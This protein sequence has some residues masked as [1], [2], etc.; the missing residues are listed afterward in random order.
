VSHRRF[1]PRPHPTSIRLS[2]HNKRRL[3]KYADKRDTTPTTLIQWIVATWLDEQDRLV[4]EKKNPS[5][6]PDSPLP[7]Y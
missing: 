6:P 7:S 4:E 5:A 2:A 1:P 3:D